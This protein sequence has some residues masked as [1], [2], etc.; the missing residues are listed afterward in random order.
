MILIIFLSQTTGEF[1]NAEEEH[2][3]NPSP[4]LNLNVT[5]FMSQYCYDATWAFAFALNKTI[6]G[7]KCYTYFLLALPSLNDIPLIL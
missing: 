6:T 2:I 1:Y 4:P 7:L 3:T 5:N